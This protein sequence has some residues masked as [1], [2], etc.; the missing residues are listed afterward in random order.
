MSKHDSGLMLP[1]EL[2]WKNSTGLDLKRR[3]SGDTQRK[4]SP[5]NRT[6]TVKKKRKKKSSLL[7][8]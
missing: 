7:I 2:G 8:Y 3:R 6:Q 1:E 5:G 4:L